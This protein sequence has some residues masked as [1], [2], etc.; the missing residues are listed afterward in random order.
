MNEDRGF[1]EQ[2]AELERTR[3]NFVVATVVA[4]RSPVSS[5]L[6]DRAII[7]DNGKMVG[8]VGGA[9]SRE[10]VRRHALE[11]LGT[12]QPRLLQIR[13]DAQA[14]EEGDVIVV[15]MG[16][17]S[18]GAVDVYIEP[19]GPQRRLLVVGFTPVAEALAQMAVV[20]DYDVVRVVSEDEARD[21]SESG[22]V[23][24]ITLGGLRAYLGELEPHARRML[25]AIVASQGQYD[26]AALELILAGPSAFV[27]LL[28]SR[29]RA[30]AVKGVLAQ[31][32]VPGD[33]LEQIRTPVG[34]DLGARSPGDVAV[35]I[36]AEI[37][38]TTPLIRG[39]QSPQ[40]ADYAE[41]ACCHHDAPA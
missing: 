11:S 20:L 38:A 22:E 16:C 18:E 12:R 34:L 15:P 36:L 25:V 27:G 35:S 2:L 23:R 30:A 28:A 4:R 26:E 6:G 9:C 29:K 24:V 7:Y 3:A 32:G 5:H 19:H 10:I 8:F 17:A 37:V 31:Q 41:H 33:A 39:E 14:G 21:L 40:S 13:P 1:F